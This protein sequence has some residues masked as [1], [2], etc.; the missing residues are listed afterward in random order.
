MAAGVVLVALELALLLT[1]NRLLI[2]ERRG[3]TGGEGQDHLECRYFTGRS[4]K[5]IQFWYA[6]NNML[7]RDSCPFL[8][9]PN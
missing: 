1:G 7:G 9:R 4:V 3:R 5:A 8:Y 2:G 6:E